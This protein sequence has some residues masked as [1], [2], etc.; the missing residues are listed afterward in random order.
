GVHVVVG[1]LRSNV[2]RAENEA[3][4]QARSVVITGSARGPSDRGTRVF[5]LSP[6]DRQLAATAYAWMRGHWGNRVC[7]L[8][9]GTARARYRAAA[10]LA[11]DPRARQASLGHGDVERCMQG[12]DAVYATALEAD[13]VFCSAVTARRSPAIA[14]VRAMALR[15]FDPTTFARAGKLWRAEPAPITRTAAI[16]AVDARYHKRAFLGATDAAL[17]FYA[18]TQIAVTA[19]RG[20]G[21][22]RVLLRN[23]RFGTILGTVR[24]NNRGE[25]EAPAI[26]VR[27][28]N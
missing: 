10:F 6:S 20:G 12:V 27:P 4:L 28:A 25:L 16:E 5:K 3:L 8:D 19:A 9:D 11:I 7:V 1:P 22:P 17:R 21:D 2:A 23:R 15:S 14:L 13:P 26:V 24:F 18:A